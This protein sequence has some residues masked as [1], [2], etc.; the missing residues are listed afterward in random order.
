MLQNTS[1]AAGHG[2]KLVCAALLLGLAACDGK[3]TGKGIPSMAF[4]DETVPNATPAS[5]NPVALG[6]P[7][8]GDLATPGDVDTFAIPLVAGRVVKFELFAT[9]HDQNG[10]GA[11]PNVPRLTLLD[12]NA[13]AN[14]KLLE[15]D[16][17]GNFS[18]G[19]SWGY[20]DLDIP[21]FLVPATGTYYVAVTQDDPT[22]PGSSFILRASYVSVPGLQHEDE[23]VVP[24]AV[25]DTIETAQLIRPGTMHGF[26]AEGD[27]D[28]Y[29]FTVGAPS[30][31]H[32]EMTA[33]RNGVYGG[34]PY[35][36]DTEI[37]L[38]DADGTTELLRNDDSIFYDSRI[39]YRIDVPGTYYL[40]VDEYDTATAPYFLTYGISALGGAR[41]SEPNDEATQADSI[42]YGE[43]RSGSID[44]G[45]ED[46]YRFSGRA[47]D[48]VR[49][50][51][52]DGGNAQQA[53]GWFDVYLY[54]T[55]GLTKLD[56]GGDEDLKTMSTILQSSGTFYVMVSGGE[57]SAD[58]TIQLTR[59]R[60]SASE[61]EPNGEIADAGTLSE[62]VAG[63]ID[64]DGDRDVFQ[65]GLR[66]DQLVR[67]VCYASNYP[68]D[69]DGDGEYSG[70]G[71]DLS[72]FLEL[73]DAEGNVVAS[74][75]SMPEGG[76]YTESVT[77]PL[78]TVGLVFTADVAGAYF[79][80]VS[81]A[82]GLGGPTHYY[83]IEYER[84]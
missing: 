16:Y 35:Y 30:I 5:A 73:L 34:T 39:E 42:A 37:A 40:V 51:Y 19:W 59:F 13:N 67:F 64:A 63:V 1:C 18:D 61:V 55:D 53:G 20:H 69:S 44:P 49:L 62:R 29:K 41:E 83:V 14:A 56:F 45:Q 23:P 75:T 3:S 76:V 25:N 26:H 38:I 36:Y 68:T 60:S 21:M 48:M 74:S 33:Y 79:V 80:R 8:H 65:I 32:F 22:L 77:Q 66:K 81:D 54:D 4:E 57:G 50:Q 10:W 15:Q 47:G 78:P 24:T 2:S 46:W 31:V 82:D 71:S 28:Y 11:A 58:Y 72:P 17:S 7:I 43:R 84:R 27:L 9:R 6:T 70:H 52:F 12:T